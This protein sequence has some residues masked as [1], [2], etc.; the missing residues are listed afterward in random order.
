MR[1]SGI[2]TA[3][4]N[5]DTKKW[6]RIINGNVDMIQK[7]VDQSTPHHVLHRELDDLKMIVANC[8][9]QLSKS[10]GRQIDIAR[11]EAAQFSK[12]ALQEHASS[13]LGNRQRGLNREDS[14]SVMLSPS[15]GIKHLDPA[16]LEVL[17]KI[18]KATQDANELM[19]QKY[20]RE[21]WKFEDLHKEHEAPAYVHRVKGF[22]VKHI[23]TIGESILLMNNKEDNIDVFSTESPNPIKTLNIQGR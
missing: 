3:S 14:L 5:F 18:Q 16:N 6:K 19:R 8:F 15:A 2:E 9:D 17:N 23:Q 7:K 12:V 11:Q 20:L 1:E 13:T 10:L 4:T 22:E 21:I